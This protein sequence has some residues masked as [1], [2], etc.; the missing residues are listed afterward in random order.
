MRP[1]TPIV[2]LTRTQRLLGLGV[3]VGGLLLTGCS[4]LE[5]DESHSLTSS[6]GGSSHNFGG[7]CFEC[8]AS[9]SGSEASEYAFTVAGSVYASSGSSTALTGDSG[10]VVKFYTQPSQ[11]GDLVLELPVDGSGNF[12]TTQSV[13]GLSSGLYPTLAYAGR[14]QSM[15]SKAAQTGNCAS[16]HA[17]GS[18]QPP[19]Y[20]P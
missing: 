13:S 9:G 14:V 4:G 11:S 15:V 6:A 19:L 12:Y 10:A 5:G 7:D 17:T 18:T 20:A 3:L 16:C 2:S 8:H 1:F